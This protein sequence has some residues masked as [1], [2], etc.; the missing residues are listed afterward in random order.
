MFNR[1]DNKYEK[2]QDAQ[3]SFFSQ[4]LSSPKV[5]NIVNQFMA[6]KH[7]VYPY[8]NRPFG[9][10]IAGLS[11]RSRIWLIKELT[12]IHLERYRR[13]N[14]AFDFRF[15]RNRFIV[16]LIPTTVKRGNLYVIGMGRH[17]SCSGKGTYTDI[18]IILDDIFSRIQP[19]MAAE[20]MHKSRI[21]GQP[22]SQVG[23][24]FRGDDL[25]YLN[26]FVFL[27]DCEV[28]RYLQTPLKT[29]NPDRDDLE[30]NYHRLPI[31]VAIACVQRMLKERQVY[32]LAPFLQNRSPSHFFT[33]SS[34]DREN[35]IKKILTDMW[36]SG[37]Y[38]WIELLNDEFGNK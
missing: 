35:A 1:T 31:G 34:E 36:E 4:N 25:N 32:G 24:Q 8:N 23:R 6:Y 10:D 33:G 12:R 9:C 7:C 11:S 17:G 26:R 13:G 3:M 2:A 16:L 19:A 22:I 5:N 30:R 15:G 18:G 20:W 38:D 28:A 29:K 37:P 14:Q 21:T 27:W